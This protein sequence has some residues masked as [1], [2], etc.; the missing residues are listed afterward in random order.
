MVFH[1]GLDEHAGRVDR[2]VRILRNPLTLR[3]DP[4]EGVVKIN[5]IMVSQYRQ[6]GS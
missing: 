4:L 1:S 5:V 2:V 3:L 6:Q